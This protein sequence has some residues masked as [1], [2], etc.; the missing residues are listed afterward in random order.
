MIP[1]HKQFEV[2]Q[3]EAAE[4]ALEGV[5]DKSKV[6]FAL[7]L[8]LS[9]TDPEVSGPLGFAARRA[10]DHANDLMREAFERECI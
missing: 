4:Q 10:G 1:N 7:K 8:M 2:A 9:V 6:H 3:K 5:S